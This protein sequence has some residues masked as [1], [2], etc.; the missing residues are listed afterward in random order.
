M[1]LQVRNSNRPKTGLTRQRSNRLLGAAL[2]AIA[3][4]LAA[5]TAL[6][7]T[8]CGTNLVYELS[9]TTLVLTSPDP[10]SSAT[11][12][13]QAFKDRTDITDVIIP[14]NV[15][16]I[17]SYAFQGCTALTEVVLPPSLTQIGNYAFN[18]CSSLHVVYC[19]PQTPPTLDQSG[20]IFVD[21]AGDLVFCVPKMSYKNIEGWNYYGDDMFQICHLDEYDE[22]SVTTG[23]I[24]QFSSG[25]PKTSIE[26]FRTLRKAR[27]FNTLTLP[28]NVPDIAASPLGGDNVEVYSFTSATVQDGTLVLNIDKVTSN[29]LSAGTPYLIQWNNTGEAL[30]RMTFTGITWDDDQLADEAGTGDV[31]YIGFYGRTQIT[32]D[33]NNSRLFLYADN[34]LYWPLDDGTSMLGFRAYFLVTTGGGALSPIRRGM[35]ATLHIKSTPTD[36]NKVQ[37]NDVQCT[38]V[39]Q[40][41]Q[42]YIMHNGTRYNVQG[43]LIEGKEENL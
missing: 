26:I 1:M 40:N 27:C 32:D 41:G 21:C 11:I 28:F 24:Q 9:G 14:D 42:L 38:K 43:Q 13:S 31:K 10:T 33:A 36:I 4:F 39:L 23:K 19:R 18:G 37:G 34:E 5:G 2:T 3:V 29:T 25:T 12:A 22:Q 30:N 15:T 17:S 35:P 7:D 8:S 20:T 6:A 16:E